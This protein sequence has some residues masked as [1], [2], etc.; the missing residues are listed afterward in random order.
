MNA[1]DRNPYT[2][3]SAAVAD[4]AEDSAL[5][6][7]AVV[8]RAVKLLWLTFVIGFL[9]AIVGLFFSPELRGAGSY[10]LLTL[11]AMLVGFGVAFGISY[12]IYGAIYAGR[13]WAR[14]LLLVLMILIVIVMVAVFGAVA[15]TLSNMQNLPP[16]GVFDAIVSVV[17]WGLSIYAT[18]LLFTR[19]ANAWYRAMKA[20]RS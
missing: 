8:V 5:E 2:P 9:S 19:P 20:Q 17:Q 3:P 11:I 12:L 4:P 7:P 16:M 6:R 15:V 1:N 18:A 10:V 13:N 14:I